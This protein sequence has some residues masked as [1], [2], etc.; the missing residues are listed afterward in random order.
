MNSAPLQKKQIV[1][2]ETDVFKEEFHDRIHFWGRLT[3]WCVIFATMAAPLYLSFVL[4]YHPGWEAIIAGIAGVTAAFGIFWFLEPVTYFPVLGISG[5]Y[6]GFLVGNISNM[7]LPCSG[8]AQTAIGA[9]PG[10][11]KAELAATLGIAAAAIVH[12]IVLVPIVLGGQYI[13]TILPE[14]VKSAFDFILPA[15]FG[16]IFAQFAI[17]VPVYGTISILLG[18]ALHLLTSLGYFG[19]IIS[20]VG[21]I[22]IAFFL[23]SQRVKN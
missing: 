18:L 22:L 2:K 23:E 6:M 1:Q 5:T 20:V 11:K 14:G 17:K 16:G 15:I 9:E 8:A 13:I 12:I 19:L 3:L 7:C 10:T 21:T 4:G